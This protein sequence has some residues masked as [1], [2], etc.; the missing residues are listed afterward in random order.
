MPTRKVSGGY[1]WGEKG[2]V[3]SRKSDADRRVRAI[4]AAKRKRKG[5]K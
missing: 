1:K 2:K 3:Y 5:K 4:E